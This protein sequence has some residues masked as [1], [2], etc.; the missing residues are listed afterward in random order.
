VTGSS[1]CILTP[2]WAKRL[3]K[4]TMKARQVSPR[5][6]DLI[7]SDHGARTVIAGKCALYLKGEIFV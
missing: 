3:A 5:G 1:H 6:G 2:F 4:K 7:V